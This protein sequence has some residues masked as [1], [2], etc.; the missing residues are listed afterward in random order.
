MFFYYFSNLMTRLIITVV[1]IILFQTAFAQNKQIQRVF[2]NSDT[3]NALQ[4]FGK[5]NHLSEQN[6]LM[7]LEEKKCIKEEVIEL[8]SRLSWL[9][10]PRLTKDNILVNDA[11]NVTDA[12]SDNPSSCKYYNASYIENIPVDIDGSIMLKEVFIG[13]CWPTVSDLSSVNRKFGYKLFLTIPEQ[14]KDK[15]YLRLK[16][17][18][19][20]FNVIDKI[21]AYKENW[22]GYWLYQEQNIFEALGN[23]SQKVSVIKHQDWAC[24]KSL[25]SKNNWYCDQRVTN[26]QYG[27][28]VILAGDKNIYNFQWHLPEKKA[29]QNNCNKKYHFVFEPTKNYTPI[30]VELNRTGYFGEIGVFDGDKCVGVASVYPSDSIIVVRSY[31]RFGHSGKLSFR[32]FD[33]SRMTEKTFNKYYKYDVAKKIWEDKF[34]YS[35]IEIRAAFVSFKNKI[36]ESDLKIKTY[37]N[38]ASNSVTVQYNA[39]SNGIISVI[40]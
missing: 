11:I 21:S 32:I 39:N 22:I 40:L 34:A 26:V 6:S 12:I 35:A 31:F 27:D 8:R 10:F 1:F 4:L 23:N 15:C 13:Y 19:K 28:M 7:L 17:K 18:V 38:P 25:F 14:Y 3:C 36:F 5:I 20:P 16:G 37:P 2:K 9:S 33:S 29:I 30:L 24:I